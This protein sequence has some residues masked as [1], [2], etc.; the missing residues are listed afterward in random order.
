MI[1]S[2]G[3]ER[4]FELVAAGILVLLG[5]R[6]LAV[7]ARRPLGSR[8]MADHVLYALFVTT[9][10]GVWFS[11]AAIAL[12]YAFAEEPQKMRGLAIVPIALAAVSTMCSYALG[13]SSD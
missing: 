10:V 5:L 6:S 2:T 4:V 3:G 9:R 13:R 1:A 7:W 11:L 12:A 8:S